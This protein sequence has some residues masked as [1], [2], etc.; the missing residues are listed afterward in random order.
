MPASIDISGATNKLKKAVKDVKRNM[1][2]ENKALAKGLFIAMSNASI[3]KGSGKK[4]KPG[5]RKAQN[6][7]WKEGPG[8]PVEYTVNRKTYKSTAEHWMARIKTKD[9]R[10]SYIDKNGKTRTHKV[11]G[12]YIIKLKTQRAPGVLFDKELWRKGSTGKLPYSWGNPGKKN[13]ANYYLRKQWTYDSDEISA[14][15]KISPAVFKGESNNDRVLRL[16]D[17]GGTGKGARRLLG[18]K[19]TFRYDKRTKKTGVGISKILE[20]KPKVIH[21]KAYYIKRQVVARVNRVLKKV[22]PTQITA[23]H[24]RQIGKGY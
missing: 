14:Q 21:V 16:L 1:A 17:T 11:H 2:N 6:G 5:S 24:W 13:L 7:D 15:T 3:K 10:E 9:L 20:D 8:L 18:F 12:F 19:L 23:Q 4:P 22:R